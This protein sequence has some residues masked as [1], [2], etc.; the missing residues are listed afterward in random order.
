MAEFD[1]PVFGGNKNERIDRD[2]AIWE[3]LTVWIDTNHNGI[4]EADEL[5]AL[6]EVGVLEIEIR[7]EYH[8]RVDQH[9]NHFYFK[10]RGLLESTDGRLKGFATTDVFFA[11][12]GE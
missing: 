2:D 8:R 3:M 1:A 4:S 12:D 10:S 6:D 7:Y 11:V 5:H 9:D